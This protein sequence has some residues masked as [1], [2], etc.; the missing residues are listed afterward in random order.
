MVTNTFKSASFQDRDWLIPRPKWLFGM[1]V[2]FLVKHVHSAER[3]IDEYDLHPVPQEFLPTEF[4]F[5]MQSGDMEELAA[6]K[7]LSHRMWP[8]PIPF[9]GG[10]RIPHIHFVDKIYMFNDKQWRRF[11][12][13]VTAQMAEKLS[14]A[15]R[16]SFEQVMELSSAIDSI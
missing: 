14:K 3:L 5:E 10:M 8:R 7:E 16:V 11:S 2:D 9:P 1:P 12:K 13:T 4:S 6:T 15:N